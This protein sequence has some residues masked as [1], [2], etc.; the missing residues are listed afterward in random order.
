[1]VVFIR[2]M[3]LGSWKMYSFTDLKACPRSPVAVVR[4][5]SMAV[6]SGVLLFVLLR[7][8]WSCAYFQKVESA[9]GT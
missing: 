5:T 6:W 7:K 3:A 9:W 1:M 8:V 4:V 2:F